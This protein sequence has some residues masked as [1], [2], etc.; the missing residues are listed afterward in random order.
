MKMGL[1]SHP[2]RIL[3][4][5]TNGIYSAGLSQTS[6]SLEIAVLACVSGI[7]WICPQINTTLGGFLKGVMLIHCAIRNLSRGR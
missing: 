5:F 2:R 3:G 7:R 1:V 6:S 4:L